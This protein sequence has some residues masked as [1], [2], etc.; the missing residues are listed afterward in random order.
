MMIETAGVDDVERLGALLAFLFEQEH[1][2]QADTV[3]QQ[4][5]L[6]TILRDE[7]RGTILV[8]REA[9]GTPAL[10]MVNV[11]YT[12]STALGSPAAILDDLVVHP[13]YRGQGVGTRLIEQAFVTAQA[14][15]CRRISLE[16]DWDNHRAQALYERFGFQKSSMFLYKK[17]F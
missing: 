14:K 4:R 13:D 12:V 15:G 6:L 1:E 16:T 17:L 8:A 10:G 3:A 5:G 11:L 9:A 7:T 2:Y